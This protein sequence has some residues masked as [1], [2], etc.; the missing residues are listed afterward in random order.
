M[1]RHGV[2]PKALAEQITE[3]M[4]KNL[5][6]YITQVQVVGPGFINFTLS[7]EYFK[8]LVDRICAEKS[9]WK[10]YYSFREENSR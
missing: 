7:S 3:E 1:Q 10:I 5:P 8:D 9:I 2:N 6:V 4:N